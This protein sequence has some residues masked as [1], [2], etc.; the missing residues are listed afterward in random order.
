MSSPSRRGNLS[1]SDL[2]QLFNT[3]AAS[4]DIEFFFA[5]I[6]GKRVSFCC[7]KKPVLPLKPEI[8]PLDDR[9]SL[10]IPPQNTAD[11]QKTA[12]LLNSIRN[13]INNE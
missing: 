7:G 8:Y 9:F 5:E 10:C 3:V 11:P 12:A 6:S 2:E 1:K 13:I 4:T